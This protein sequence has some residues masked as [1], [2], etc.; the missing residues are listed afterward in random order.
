MKD[1][2]SLIRLGIGK[3]LPGNRKLGSGALRQEVAWPD[4]Q[5]WWSRESKARGNRRE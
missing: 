4:V 3:S 1:K 5:C 2:Y